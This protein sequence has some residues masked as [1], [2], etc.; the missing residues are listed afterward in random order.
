MN[1]LLVNLIV[2]L[3][4]AVNTTNPNRSRSLCSIAD[5]KQ[6]QRHQARQCSSRG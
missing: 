6:N 3:V 5:Q 2:T 4:T 1:E